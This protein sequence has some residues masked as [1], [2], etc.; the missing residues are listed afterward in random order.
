MVSH[1]E[2]DGEA[3]TTNTLVETA[4]SFEEPDLEDQTF[5]MSLFPR[6]L[7]PTDPRYGRFFDELAHYGREHS[8]NKEKPHTPFQP[9]FDITEA[10]DVYELHGE[11]PGLDRDNISIDFVEPQTL[12]IHG[13]VESSYDIP[14]PSEDTP[15]EAS[16]KTETADP[17][18]QVDQKSSKAEP[19]FWAAERNFGEFSRTFTF[20]RPVRQNEVYAK[21]DKGIL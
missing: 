4:H 21:L 18:S 10:D 6:Y 8:S 5:K 2:G 19:R 17:A 16:S 14:I 3:Y 20:P 11:L 7:H 9:T 13:H 1:L 15:A 12:V